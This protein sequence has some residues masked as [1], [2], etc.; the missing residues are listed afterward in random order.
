MS[1][2]DT[3]SR[4]CDQLQTRLVELA[5]NLS[6][7]GMNPRAFRELISDLKA[8]VDDAA[9]ESLGAFI[10][11][12]EERSELIEHEGH[13]HR[14]KA[15]TEKNWLT[16]FGLLSV[17]RRYF[18]QDRGGIGIVP[19]DNRCGMSHRYM[20][21]DIEEACAMGSALL[22]PREIEAFLEKVLPYA[23]SATA[24]QKVIEHVGGFAEKNADIIE[25]AIRTQAPLKATGSVLAISWDGVTVP[26]REEG[27]KLGKPKER[28]GK[29]APATCPT[30]WREAGV[31]T[32]SI[33][34]RGTAT[35]RP[36]RGDS[37]YFARMPEQ[38][39]KTLTEQ[40]EGFVE[41]LR[42]ERDFEDVVVLCD[43]KPSIWKSA[44]A[45][46]CYK[47]A[48]FILDFYHA[49]EHLSKVAETIFGKK[50]EK[51]K[52]WYS[53]YRSRMKEDE[54]G[55]QA[56]IRSLRRYTLGARLGSERREDLVRSLGYFTRNKNRMRYAEYRMRGLPIGSG[57]V[58]AACKT[59]VGA[60]LKR[61]GMRWNREGG[62][63]VL[64]M[65]VQY[66]SKRWKPF[67][68]VYMADRLAA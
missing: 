37:R 15:S 68:R 48:T 40:M 36:L 61:S 33:Y 50:S 12:Q 65:R 55:V 46:V 20:T 6:S 49:A 52:N 27:N 58:E 47:G 66:L 26:L 28:P 30:A 64:N 1:L 31:G 34:E 67:W 60:R 56:V 32:V 9:L 14:F 54:G 39:M 21:P 24:V 2:T 16:P 41:A 11:S 53:K 43:G 63:R 35:E 13:K 42:A 23:P 18:Q 22:V 19:L 59:V 57:P 5:E 45:A 7:E 44:E 8:S 62:Q 25:E 38:G 29:D 4:V 17:P 10:A 3:L 51:G